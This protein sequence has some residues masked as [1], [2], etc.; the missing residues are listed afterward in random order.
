MKNDILE[1]VS[2]LRKVFSKMKTQLKNK[3]EEN[4]KLSKE[5]MKVTEEMVR[6]RNSQPVIQVAPSLDHKQEISRS[7]AQPVPPSEGRR[8]KLFVE[9]LK[10]GADKRYKLT[11]TAK[12]KSQ[13]P[14]QI[15]LQLKKD[16]NPTDIKVG[17]KTLKTLRDGR[18]LVETDSE[19]EINSLSL[20]ISTKCGEQLEIRKHTLRKPTLILYVS[21]ETTIENATDIIKAQNPDIVLNEDNIVA[22]FRYKTR[23]GNYNLVTEVRPQTQKQILHTKLKIGREIC[24]VE[25]YLVHTRC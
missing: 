18:I 17:V 2:T 22:K 8:K 10:D 24:N 25:D 7:E 15:K 13:S 16:I 14:E 1:S 11:L 4:K 23:K 12:G 5:F 9:V 19:E 21:E 20:A 3:S 6:M